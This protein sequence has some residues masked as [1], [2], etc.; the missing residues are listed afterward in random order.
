V[1][2][3]IEISILGFKKT[4]DIVE[5]LLHSQPSCGI[6]R[7]TA[8]YFL[9]PNSCTSKKRNLVKLVNSVPAGYHLPFLPSNEMH[10]FHHLVFNENFGTTTVGFLDW[11]HGTDKT[12]RKRGTHV[13]HHVLWGTK[14]AR[15]LHACQTDKVR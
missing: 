1:E 2:I 5:S 9:L 4:S 3:S 10:D 7:T 8:D 14:S 13:R 11:F 15:E 12:W 6:I